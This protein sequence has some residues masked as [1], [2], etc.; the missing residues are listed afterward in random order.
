MENGGKHKPE[1]SGLTHEDQAIHD[2]NQQVERLNELDSRKTDVDPS[3][4][5]NVQATLDSL[6]VR[7]SLDLAHQQTQAL[8]TFETDKALRYGQSRRL[9][10][11]KDEFRRENELP[12]IRVMEAKAADQS[13]NIIDKEEEELMKLRDETL[14]NLPYFQEIQDVHD[15]MMANPNMRDEAAEQSLEALVSFNADMK[16]LA[17]NAYQMEELTGYAMEEN[18][19][20]IEWLGHMEAST[21]KVEDNLFRMGTTITEACAKLKKENES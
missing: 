18:D 21:L 15:L 20:M 11:I 12:D 9:Q 6:Q 14:A 16:T 3:F 7:D 2:K 10:Q 19:L 5:N 8:G 17:L 4:T 1:P 13:K